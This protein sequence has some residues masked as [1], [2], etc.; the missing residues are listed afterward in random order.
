M[1]VNIGFNSFDNWVNEFCTKV[2]LV[3]PECD[4]RVPIE[5]FLCFPLSDYTRVVDFGIG[6]IVNVC[7][8]LYT[9]KTHGASKLKG[10]VDTS[11]KLDF[12][13]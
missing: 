1:Y 12:W 6:H 5:I 3:V 2:P 4:M 8:Y 10:H 9:N 7:H 13:E 11:I